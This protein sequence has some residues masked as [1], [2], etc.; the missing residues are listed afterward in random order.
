MVTA[1]LCEPGGNVRYWD[2]T[3]LLQQTRFCF[4]LWRRREYQLLI[5]SYFHL[6]PVMTS[7]YSLSVS[8]AAKAFV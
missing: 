7:R 2:Q 3:A 4:R 6:I 8:S 5:K 1:F